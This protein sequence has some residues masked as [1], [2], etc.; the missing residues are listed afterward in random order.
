[1]MQGAGSVLHFYSIES[2]LAQPRNAVFGQLIASVIGVGICK[3]FALSSRFESIRWIGGALSCA[4]ATAVMALTK[5]VHPPAGATALLAVVS[6]D[7]LPLGWLLVPL[8][9]LGSVLMLIVAL[10][11]NNIQ[12]Q[13]PQYWWSPE[14]LS[15]T[16][17]RGKIVEDDRD[18]DTSTAKVKDSSGKDLEKKS[19]SLP[20][21]SEESFRQPRIII[22]RGIVHAPS[23]LYLMPEERAFLEELSNRL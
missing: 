22:Q 11:I 7:S 21:H 16:S 5:T 23:H 18:T 10:L 2:P 20:R 9:L 17:S 15:P 19:L 6:N 3:L 13:F 12:R 1:M 4:I 14:D 8:M